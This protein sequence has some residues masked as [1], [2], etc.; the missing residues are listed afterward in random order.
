VK[1]GKAHTGTQNYKCKVCDRRFVLDPIWREI[2][3][4]TKKRI[5][6]LLP[7]RVSLTG[8]ARVKRVS[9]SWPQNYVNER[10]A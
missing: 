8:I 7:E 9:E 5:D 6:K 3:E 4:V 1:N 10:Y 2:D